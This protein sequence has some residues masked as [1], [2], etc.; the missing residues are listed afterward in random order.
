MLH[1]YDELCFHLVRKGQNI[2]QCAVLLLVNNR[3]VTTY[4]TSCGRVQVGRL[5]NQLFGQWREIVIGPYLGLRFTE[6]QICHAAHK[7]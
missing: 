1:F 2:K 6:S 4:G 7:P 5:K 3:S